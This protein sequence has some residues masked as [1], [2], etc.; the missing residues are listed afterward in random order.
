M[1]SV[2]KYNNLVAHLVNEIPGL[3]HYI[4]AVREEQFKEKVKNISRDQLPLLLAV[5]PSAD[6]IGDHDNYSDRDNFLM[7]VLTKRDG[8][9]K[10]DATMVNDFET[11]QS[12]AMTIK[13]KLI[14]IS[15][16][17][18][19]SFHAELEHLMIDSF[20]VDPEFNFLG[21]DGWSLTF[22]CRSY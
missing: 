15:G 10:T 22:S 18:E 21:F 6:G 11:T 5:I 17:C 4:L 12:I 14:E 1:I 16:D 2:S 7:F 13:H 9:D 3:R 19:A 20:H 8:S